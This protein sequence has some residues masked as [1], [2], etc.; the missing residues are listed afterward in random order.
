MLAE[1]GSADEWLEWL[2]YKKLEADGFKETTPQ[3]RVL[4]DAI[5]TSALDDLFGVGNGGRS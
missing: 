1:I 3:A 4:T 5:A 2:A